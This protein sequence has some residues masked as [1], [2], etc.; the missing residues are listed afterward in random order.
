MT[1]R[2][3]PSFSSLPCGASN[4]HVRRVRF[5]IYYTELSAAFFETLCRFFPN[6]AEIDLHMMEF[7]AYSW[8][9]T[10][11]DGWTSHNVRWYFGV[12]QKFSQALAS[13][14]GTFP[15]QLNVHMPFGQANGPEV[16][17]DA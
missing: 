17:C 11:H 7:T 12:V 14:Q 16:R 4:V 13:A 9:P 2:G 5:R 8:Q 15:V 6:L 3:G 1:T 10:T